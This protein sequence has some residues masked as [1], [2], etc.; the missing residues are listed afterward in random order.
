MEAADI[1]RNCKSGIDFETKI[2]KI[3][4]N[5]GFKAERVGKG[6]KG[7]D[8]IAITPSGYTFNIQCKFHNKSIDN[9]SVNQVFAGTAYYDN[10][11]APVL[12]TN[13]TA[14]AEAR[15]VTQ[16]LKVEIIADAE[17]MEQQQVYESQRLINPHHGLM[18]MI[19]SYI[20]GNP[21]YLGIK[22]VQDKLTP[23]QHS[24]IEQFKLNLSTMFDEAD[25]HMKEA[26]SLQLKAAQHQQC[27]ISLQKK[28][29]LRNIDT[30]IENISSGGLPISM[31][32][33][34]ILDSLGTLT[35]EQK[36]ELKSK[37]ALL[38]EDSEG[39]LKGNE[40]RP[41]LCPHCK[42]TNIKKID[43][44]SVGA[45]RFQCKEC[46]RLIQIQAGL[47]YSAQSYHL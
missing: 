14:T 30:G 19:I 3:L 26:M 36:S 13:N 16:K 41:S 29:L 43:H 21:D 9:S 37:L 24:K 22:N 35:Q 31:S 39:Q 25:T 20:L 32:F 4:I 47:C 28:A 6:D 17:W 46:K 27:A 11:G 38:D 45:Q 18:G 40:N 5:M 8:I 23:Q 7:V 12:I 1:F 2:C 33:N 42:N 15:L 34:E 10:G 44:T